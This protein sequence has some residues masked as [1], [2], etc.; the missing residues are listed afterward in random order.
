MLTKVAALEFKSQAIR[1]NCVSPAAV[2]TPMWQKCP[3][4]E[5]WLKNMAVSR[6]HGMRWGAVT[7][8]HRRY[9]EWRFQ[10]KSPVR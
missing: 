9:S 10:P 5:T 4:G 3:S 1:V 7:L 2:V 6:V 8:L